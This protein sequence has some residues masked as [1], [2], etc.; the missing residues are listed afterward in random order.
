[1]KGKMEPSAVPTMVKVMPPMV[2]VVKQ[3]IA[4]AQMTSTQERQSREWG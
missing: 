2:Q 4:V 1:M 3:V